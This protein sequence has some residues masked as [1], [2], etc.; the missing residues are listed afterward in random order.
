M[1]Q[2]RRGEMNVKISDERAN[3]P[4]SAVF[5]GCVSLVFVVVVVVSMINDRPTTNANTQIIVTSKGFDES[6]RK[7]EGPHQLQ[8]EDRKIQEMHYFDTIVEAVPGAISTDFHRSVR[9][10]SVRPT[11]QEMEAALGPCQQRE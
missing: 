1:G 9:K 8:F 2:D 10:L 5:L 6:I 11:R 3:L 7:A 4:G